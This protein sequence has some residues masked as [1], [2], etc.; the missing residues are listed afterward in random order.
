MNDVWTAIVD[1]FSDLPSAAVA[2]KVAIRL[3]LAAMLGAALGYERE[4]HRHQRAG[5]RTHMLISLG[6]A[7]FTLVPQMA[8]MSDDAVSRVIQGLVAGIGFLGAGPILKL[9]QR[10]EV[11]GLTTAA[12]IWVA[13]AVGVTAGVGRGMMAILTTVLALVILAFL[14]QFEHDKDDRHAQP[15]PGG[16]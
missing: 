2:A 13:A 9:E 5:M 16:A 8:H 10:M 11:K 12:S 4:H 14:P 3:L 7:T 6:S 1:N 15:A